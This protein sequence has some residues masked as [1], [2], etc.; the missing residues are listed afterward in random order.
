MKV[1]GITELNVIRQKS[2]FKSHKAQQSRV[3]FNGVLNAFSETYQLVQGSFLKGFRLQV[4]DAATSTI[5]TDLCDAAKYCIA[6]SYNKVDSKCHL[7]WYGYFDYNI[8][9]EYGIYQIVDSNFDNYINTKFYSGSQFNLTGLEKSRV[10]DGYL[11]QPFASLL[12]PINSFTPVDSNIPSVL[13]SLG[14]NIIIAQTNLTNYQESMSFARPLKTKARFL[15]PN[16]N[17]GDEDSTMNDG[18]FIRASVGYLF[19]STSIGVDGWSD[20][21]IKGVQLTEVSGDSL[22]DCLSLCTETVGCQYAAYE[23]LYHR[24]LIFNSDENEY[25]YVYTSMYIDLFVVNEGMKYKPQV[26]LKVQGINLGANMSSTISEC[27]AGCISNQN[28]VAVNYHTGSLTCQQLSTIS[29]TIKEFGMLRFKIQD[30]LVTSASQY[31]STSIY[32]HS[33]D[34]HESYLQSSMDAYYEHSYSLHESLVEHE[35]SL[36]AS[37]ME[38]QLVHDANELES[39]AVYLSMEQESTAIYR[40]NEQESTANYLANEVE[41]TRAYFQNEYLSTLAYYEAQDSTEYYLRLLAQSSHSTQ[42]KV[43]DSVQTTVIQSNVIQTT[44]DTTL[45]TTIDSSYTNYVS[46][47]STTSDSTSTTVSI[48]ATVTKSQTSTKIP[49]EV[50]FSSR[51]LNQ[52]SSASAMATMYVLS[53]LLVNF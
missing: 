3:L 48:E 38:S 33:I 43:L 47:T 30:S 21:D 20:N 26:D 4:Y 16:S 39:T 24:C 49:D 10:Y 7:H 8:Q 32:L 53:A 25:S 17:S 15:L 5:C 36:T 37:M 40:A 27:Y 18:I 31:Q 46:T 23:Y 12:N 13:S 22:Y 9:N 29:G 19:N 1:Y 35:Q 11:Y 41:S 50:Y 34:V 28:C 52:D 2:H 44:N 42:S 6:V 45:S 51:L 14:D